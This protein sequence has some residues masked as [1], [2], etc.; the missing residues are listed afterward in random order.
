MRFVLR[1]TDDEGREITSTANV[2]VLQPSCQLTILKVSGLWADE[3]IWTVVHNNEGVRITRADWGI[4]HGDCRGDSIDTLD[5]NESLM[6]SMEFDLD[7]QTGTPDPE[8]VAQ[9]VATLEQIE[10][11]G[12][13][14]LLPPDRVWADTMRPMSR[15]HKTFSMS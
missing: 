4:F 1:W 11:K 10:C 12:V 15:K 6:V 13:S 14:K 9:W 2:D 7:T 5:A 8:I 3:T